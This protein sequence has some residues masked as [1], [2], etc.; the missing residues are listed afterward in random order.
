MQKITYKWGYKEYPGETFVHFELLEQDGGTTV[1]ITHEGI[2]G[3][4]QDIPEFT[5]EACEGGWNYFVKG[6]LKTYL[7][8]GE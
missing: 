3:F 4:S 7:E 1:R 5:P 2:S 8:S 6:R